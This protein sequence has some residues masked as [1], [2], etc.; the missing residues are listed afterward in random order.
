MKPQQSG[1]HFEACTPQL[2]IAFLETPSFKKAGKYK[3]V[4]IRK[5]RD[6]DLKMAG[7]KHLLSRKQAS[8]LSD[9]GEVVVLAH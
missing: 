2:G 5:T 1:G 3:H 8:L 7:V 4:R 6:L 9:L